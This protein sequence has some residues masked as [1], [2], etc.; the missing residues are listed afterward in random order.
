[1]KCGVVP[2]ARD[3]CARRYDVGGATGAR[4]EARDAHPASAYEENMP[5]IRR[6]AARCIIIDS[7]KTDHPCEM[8]A[9]RCC[10]EG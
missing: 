7:T 4:N 1:M 8:F 3:Q 9:S 5:P 6:R 2:G 10:E